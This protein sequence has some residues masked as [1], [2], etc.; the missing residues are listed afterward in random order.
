MLVV[1]VITCALC[2]LAIAR[3]THTHSIRAAPPKSRSNL[4]S[5][6]CVSAALDRVCACCLPQI[7]DDSGSAVL[8]RGGGPVMH[9]S[10]RRPL[11]VAAFFLAHFIAASNMT[12]PQTSLR[13]T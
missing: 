13:L 9:T 10:R 11:S 3:I 5:A 7:P 8:G 1:Y 6:L 12:E 4:A 2:P